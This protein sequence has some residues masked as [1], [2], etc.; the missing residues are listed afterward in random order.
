[1]FGLPKKPQIL[2]APMLSS[3]GGGSARGFNPGG[4]GGLLPDLYNF[5]S[6]TFTSGDGRSGRTDDTGPTLAQ[7]QADYS[8]TT[9]A[10]N[11]AYLNMPSNSQGVQRWAVPMNG[12][13]TMNLIGAGGASSNAGSSYNRGADV[14]FTVDLLVG[15]YLD[16]VVGQKGQQVMFDGGGGGGSFVSITGA[17]TS[18]YTDYVLGVGGGGGGGRAQSNYATGTTAQDGGGSDPG[19]AG[20][21]GNGGGGTPANGSGGGGGGLISIGSAADDGNGTPANPFLINNQNDRSKGGKVNSANG[22]SHGGFGG[23]G[24]GYVNNLESSGIYSRPGGGGG[25]N[26]GGAG[27]YHGNTL[28]DAYGGYGSSYANTS[29]VTGVSYGQGANGA[30]DGSVVITKI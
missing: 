13:Y 5:T 27:S 28:A 22:T 18:D 7:I 1:M 15:Q 14:H 30:T 26:G 16:I 4:G 9:W 21:N 6:H 29:L 3:F 23:G 25:Y 10:S 2:Y 12:T 19:T 8:H 20:T 24:T 11:T 17:S